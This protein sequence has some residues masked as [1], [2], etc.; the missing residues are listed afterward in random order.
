MPTWPD[1][2]VCAAVERARRHDLAEDVIAEYVADELAGDE[3]TDGAALDAMRARL[4]ELAERGLVARVGY[5]RTQLWTLTAAGARLVPG[6]APLL[7]ESRQHRD[8]RRAREN[9]TTNL[10][11]LRSELKREL[12]QIEAMLNGP[13]LPTP[14][15]IQASHRIRHLTYGMSVAMHVLHERPEPTD[16]K[17]AQSLVKVRSPADWSF[18]QYELTQASGAH[19]AST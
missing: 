18:F 11:T 14:T 4:A 5:H 1:A 7:P 9:A 6:G 13:T 12:A 15:W 3:P 16:D 17:T 19:Q 2:V 10:E 8:W